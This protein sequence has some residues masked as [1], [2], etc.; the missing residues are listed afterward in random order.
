MLLDRQGVREVRHEVP[1]ITSSEAG[2]EITQ[3]TKKMLAGFQG[4]PWVGASGPLTRALAA[5]RSP[6]ADCSRSGKF[7]F[8]RGARF[9]GPGRSSY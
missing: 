9:Y 6:S 1:S 3:L 5:V 4:I 8:G 7:I 2:H